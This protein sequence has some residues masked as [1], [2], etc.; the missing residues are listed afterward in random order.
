MNM[1]NNQLSD[2]RIFELAKEH[3][4]RKGHALIWETD[5][6]YADA[7]GME[8][9]ARWI[10]TEVHPAQTVAFARAIAAELSALPAAQPVAREPDYWLRPDSNACVTPME[11]RRM[12][13]LGYGHWHE[14]SKLYTV[15]L[16]AAPQPAHEGAAGEPQTATH[17]VWL[18][19]QQ[20]GGQPAYLQHLGWSQR[21]D[22]K[23]H[24][25][26][27]WSHKWQEAAMFHSVDAADLVVERINQFPVFDD[28][29]THRGW[30]RVA[31]DIEI[32][33]DAA[34]SPKTGE[35]SAIEGV[36]ERFKGGFGKAAMTA[37]EAHEVFGNIGVAS[38]SQA[39]DG[40]SN[41]DTK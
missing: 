22:G 18:I 2:E 17:H 26:P 28:D 23:S 40:G 5:P 15:P 20:I 21:T 36:P 27:V 11:K 10:L 34:P 32:E 41:K 4:G 29:N 7:L 33:V 9:D 13:N 16:Y 30:H 14:A 24:T 25:H 8:K 6:Q 19:E 37:E 3:F 35:G 31:H 12:A 1:D 39:G 38:G